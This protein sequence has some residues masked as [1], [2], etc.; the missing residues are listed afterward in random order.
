MEGIIKYLVEVRGIQNKK[1]VE[2][3]CGKGVFLKILCRLGGNSGVGFDPS[4]IGPEEDLEG[5]VKFHRLIYRPDYVRI[6][7]DV[8]ICRHVIEHVADPVSLLNS[9][10]QALLKSQQSRMFIET[11][12]LE[13]ILK[14]Q[15]FWDFFYEHC[16]YFVKQSLSTAFGIAGF[17]V[18]SIQNVFNDQYLWLEARLSDR[19]NKN[20]T[21]WPGH[22]PTLVKQFTAK[23]EALIQKWQNRLRKLNLLGKVGIWGAG[24]KGVTFANLVDPKCELIDC[25]VD[26]N[27]NKQ[28]RFV[29]GTGH[30]IISY[31]ELPTRNVVTSILMNP[32]YREETQLLLQNAGI[33]LN[34]IDQRER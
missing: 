1:I 26:L 22:I 16:S 6:P 30:P 24:A 9:A 34:M 28:G 23:D 14:N 31:R 10:K 15:I 32:N 17:Q 12:C 4:Y 25:V 19:K 33:K 13:W 18:E 7:A 5:R 2:V 29:P 8:V 27:P 3:G 11:P 21:T 20:V